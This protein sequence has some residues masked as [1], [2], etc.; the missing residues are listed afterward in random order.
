M[1]KQ[2]YEMYVYQGV[3]T[4]N[5]DADRRAMEYQA[6]KGPV[7]NAAADAPAGSVKIAPL[8]RILCGYCKSSQIGYTQTL[9]GRPVGGRFHVIL[10]TLE[11]H[12]SASVLKS[13]PTVLTPP[14][15]SVW[16]PRGSHVE[17]WCRAHGAVNVSLAEAL[18]RTRDMPGDAPKSVIWRVK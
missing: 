13:V 16:T 1:S 5:A 3:A 2:R 8:V 7:N 10:F 12:T 15:M 17:A 11:R 14:S 18:Q 4:I 6:L 9:D